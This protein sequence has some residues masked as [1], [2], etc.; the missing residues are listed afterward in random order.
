MNF[1][2]IHLFNQFGWQHHEGAASDGMD[3]QYNYFENLDSSLKPSLLHIRRSCEKNFQIQRE[4]G[5][6]DML[7]D[8]F[9]QKTREQGF[10]S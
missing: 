3:I 10:D 5:D 1:R 4:V 8:H 6:P 9:H 2:L 7:K